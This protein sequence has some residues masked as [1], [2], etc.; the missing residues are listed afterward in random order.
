MGL[1]HV[2]GMWTRVRRKQIGTT[3]NATENDTNK[4]RNVLFGCRTDLL[5]RE[6]NEIIGGNH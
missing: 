4:K 6:L 2:E 5:Q 3:Q 1:R